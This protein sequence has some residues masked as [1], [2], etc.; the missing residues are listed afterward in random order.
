MFSRTRLSSRNG[1]RYGYFFV[2]ISY[3]RSYHKSTVFLSKSGAFLIFFAIFLT[4]IPT[5][6]GCRYFE[7][8][9]LK[10]KINSLNNDYT[11]FL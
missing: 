5:Q 10:S 4:D 6:G 2:L 9:P 3:L 7:H 8:P 1:F 11:Y